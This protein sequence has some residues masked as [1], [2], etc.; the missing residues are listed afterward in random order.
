VRLRIVI[1]GCALLALAA[2]GGSG[3]QAGKAPASSASPAPAR[4]AAQG[5]VAGQITQLGSGSLVV[6]EPT[7][8]ISVGYGPAT[9]VLQT[10]SATQSNIL[11]GACVVVTGQ[12]ESAGAV[13]ASTV[14]VQFNMNGVCTPPPGVAPGGNGPGNAVNLRGK[15]TSVS[16]A[17]FVMQPVTAGDA[18]VA[19]N[20]PSA[21][22]ITRLDTATTSRLAVGQ[23]VR[24]NGQQDAAGVVQARALVITLAGPTGCAG[25]TGG[26]QPR[27]SGPGAP[28][29]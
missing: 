14:Q 27:P 28:A 29:A 3:G 22:R 20:V 11:A 15:I 16:G 5:G 7:G 12:R 8:D 2:C 24:V 6:R 17:S 19:V 25:P 21:A 18:P 10:S 4:G 9:G 13:T 26:A 23:C 1:V